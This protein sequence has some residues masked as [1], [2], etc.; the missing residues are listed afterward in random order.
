MKVLKA[1]G[2]VALVIT[3]T[4]AVAAATTSATTLCKENKNECPVGQR[5]P[6]KETILAGLMP[7]TTLVYAGIDS[8]GGITYA[9]NCEESS[10]SWST[11]KNQGPGEV[12]F[13]TLTA[14]LF[15]KCKNGTS[16][17]EKVTAE[18]LPYTT[19]LIPSATMG[20]G[21]LFLINGGAGVRKLKLEKCGM[22][23]VNCTYE[24]SEMGYSITGGS[25]ASMKI[26]WEIKS[27][28]GNPLCG[29]KLHMNGTYEAA[30]PKP[31]WV[32]AK[33]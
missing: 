18:N 12:L 16:P 22:F 23:G 9:G 29:E 17:C 5:Y 27:E 13:G 4:T 21:S 6:E 2:L 3:A 26:V 32:E 28:G 30:A 8:F 11:T 1:I 24:S 7:K 25:P 33:P 19:E 14:L 31:L 10:L 15:G 20:N